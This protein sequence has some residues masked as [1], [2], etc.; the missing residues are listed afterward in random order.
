MSV[1]LVA[2]GK[3]GKGTKRSRNNKQ[4]RDSSITKTSQILTKTPGYLSRF[5]V[6][7]IP[8]K[9]HQLT[10]IILLLLIIA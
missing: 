8:V 3:L 2:N 9:D 10:T 7:Q 5:D 6:T 1:I 4:D